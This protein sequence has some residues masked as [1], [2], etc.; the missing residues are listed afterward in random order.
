MNQAQEEN[1]KTIGQ[2]PV[3]VRLKTSLWNVND[4][5]CF[6]HL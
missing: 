5:D 4:V 1:P 3:G 6:Q 2:N